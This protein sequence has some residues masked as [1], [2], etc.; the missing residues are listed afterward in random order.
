MMMMPAWGLLVAYVCPA[1]RTTWRPPFATPEHIFD[2]LDPKTNERLN[3]AKR[4][5][6][7]ALEQ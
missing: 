7:V 3:E 4:F 6:R 1:W 5:L 2:M